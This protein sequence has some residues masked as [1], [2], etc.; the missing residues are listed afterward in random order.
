MVPLA[1][2]SQALGG[3]SN[4]FSVNIAAAQ[5]Y[6]TQRIYGVAPVVEDLLAHLNPAAE[7]FGLVLTYCKRWQIS[8]AEGQH[9]QSCADT[10]AC[11]DFCRHSLGLDHCMA[12]GPPTTTR[13]TLLD[14]TP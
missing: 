3:T 13:I 6:L 14:G 5:I 11:I 1:E 9:V 12:P 2:R 8:R 4:R 7:P 10:R